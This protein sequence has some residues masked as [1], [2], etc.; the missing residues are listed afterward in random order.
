MSPFEIDML[1]FAAEWAPYGGNDEAAFLRFGL[2]PDQFHRRL[3]HL[4]ASPAA[5]T[6]DNATAARLRQQCA[7]RVG[8]RSGR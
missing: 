3:T 5:R 4:L 6:L 1:E 7:D 2:T 8:R